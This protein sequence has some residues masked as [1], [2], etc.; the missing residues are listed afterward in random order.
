MG[1]RISYWGINPTRINT[2]SQE[3]QDIDQLVIDAIDSLMKDGAARH[4]EQ[5]VFN[6]TQLT[7]REMR[8]FKRNNVTLTKEPAPK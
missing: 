3:I 6:N 7:P 5:P 4:G 1:T 8:A 2:C